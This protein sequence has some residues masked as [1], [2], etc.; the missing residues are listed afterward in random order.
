MESRGVTWGDELGHALMAKEGR[1]DGGELYGLGVRVLTGEFRP[2]SMNLLDPLFREE[3]R[4][5]GDE[6]EALSLGSNPCSHGFQETRQASRSVSVRA[7]W[8]D[9]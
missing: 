5:D 4:V 3:G 2:G 1:G 7:A 9:G 8:E 6:A